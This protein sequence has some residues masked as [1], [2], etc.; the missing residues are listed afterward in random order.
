LSCSKK[1]KPNY[2]LRGRPLSLQT[3][4]KLSNALKG[5]VVSAETRQKLRDAHLGRPG[6]NIGRKFSEETKQKMSDAW[7]KS[8]DAGKQKPPTFKGKYHSKETKQRMREK[9]LSQ[10]TNGWVAY[11]PNACARIDEYGKQHGYNFQHAENGGEVRV[12]GYSV[13]GYDKDKNVVIEYYE[14][15]H[16]KPKHKLRDAQRKRRIIDHLG[17]KF[18][19]LKEE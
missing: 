1:G 8:F 11:N 13:D 2:K 12:I 19:E 18:I 16:N 17:C 10:F 9:R 14:K 3:R 15:H 5:R 4:Q 6:V 7:Y